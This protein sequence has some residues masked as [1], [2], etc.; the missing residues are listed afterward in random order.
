M[1]TI[2]DHTDSKEETKIWVQRCSGFKSMLFPHIHIVSLKSLFNDSVTLLR[3]RLAWTP[4]GS[5]SM[6]SMLTLLRQRTLGSILEILSQWEPC[7]SLR[8]AHLAN[9]FHCGVQILTYLYNI[10]P[11]R[12]H[13]ILLLSLISTKT[14]TTTIKQ[15]NYN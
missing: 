13:N 1:E 10:S 3:L 2:Q 5:N 8:I 15:L 6:N 7:N 14:V 4:T 11:D 9:V 12:S